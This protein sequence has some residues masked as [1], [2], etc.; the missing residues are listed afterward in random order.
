MH[1]ERVR[2]IAIA[3]RCYGPLGPA[4]YEMIGCYDG[5]CSCGA[6]AVP[7]ALPPVEPTPIEP[8]PM[9]AAASAPPRTPMLYAPAMHPP[10][11]PYIRR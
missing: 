9:D 1:P 5:G 3:P 11:S 4:P 6:P 10:T 2:R 7:I 8:T